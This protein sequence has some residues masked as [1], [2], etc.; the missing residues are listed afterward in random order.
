MI[1]EIPWQFLST[2]CHL[3]IGGLSKCL[4]KLAFCSPYFYL[5]QSDFPFELIF[6]IS[7]MGSVC[8]VLEHDVECYLS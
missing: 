5:L 3:I 1:F 4:L 7:V 6:V 2:S 8:K